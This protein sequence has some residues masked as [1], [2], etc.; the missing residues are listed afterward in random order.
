MAT[1][2]ILQY[3][4]PRLRHVAAP[5]DAVDEAVRGLAADMLETMYAAHGI[6]LAATQVGVDR[7]VCVIDVSEAKDEP[8]VLINP[9]ISWREGSQESVE[10][11][12]SIPDVEDKV[13]RAERVGVRALDRD[14]EAFE[15]DTDGLLA[16]CVQHE[17]D[18]LDGRLFIDHLSL[19]KRQ[20]IDKRL[21]KQRRR[22]GS[23]G[24]RAAG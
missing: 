1:L 3:P 21:T 5:V 12:L 9:E 10:G 4:D 7:R 15:L 22:A 19:L 13:R 8:L 2:E 17:I 20:R 24:R 14:G 18:H 16:V 11:C 6:G 23:S